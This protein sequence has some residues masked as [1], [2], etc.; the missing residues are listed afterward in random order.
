MR[1]TITGRHMDMTDALKA[2]VENG[3]EKVRGHFDRVID[4]SVVLSVEKHRHVAEINLH[5]NGIRIHG[6]ESSP[7]MYASVDAV[8][9][10]LDKQV[11]RFKDR[12]NRHQPRK[13]KERRDYGHNVIEIIER[14]NEDNGKPP[15][16]GHRVTLREKLSM[17]PM[18]VE[19][20]SMQ[21]ELVDDDFVV[22]LNADSQQVNVIYAR[23]DGTYGLIEPQF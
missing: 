12:I 19:E 10:K 4:A 15:V 5:A 6:K 20:A 7:D 13:S 1:V 9:E 22:F 23:D 16:A 3:L 18:S 17:K 8:L 2:Y 14:V 21:L 11:R